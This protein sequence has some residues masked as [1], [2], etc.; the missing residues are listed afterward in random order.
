MPGL[1]PGRLDHVTGPAA[2]TG[3]GPALA[4]VRRAVARV[5]PTDATVLVL[6]ETGTGKELVARAVH[7]AEPAGTTRPFVPVSCVALA[8]GL[9]TSELFGHEAGAFTGAGRRRVGRFEQADGGTL[10]LDEAGEMPPDAQAVLLRALQERVIERVGGEA[11]PVDVRVVAATNRDLPAEVAAGRFRA[12]LY[13]RLAVFPVTVPPL[14]DRR[15]DISELVEQFTRVGRHAGTAGRRSLCSTSTLR[16]LAAHDWPGNVRELQNLVERA[17]ILSDGPDLAFDP[18]WLAGGTAAETAK[19]WAAQEKRRLL[20]ALRASRRPGVRPRRGG[21]PAGPQPDHPVRQDA[22]ARHRPHGRRVGVITGRQPTKLASS[23][24]GRNRRG[25]LLYFQRG[26]PGALGP[27]SLTPERRW[28]VAHVVTEPCV[29]CKHSDCVVVCPCE[30]FYA[31]D[32]QLYIDPVDCID[33]G[34]CVPECPVEAIFQ[35]DDVPAKWAGAVRLNADRVASAEGGRVA[36]GDGEAAGVT[37][38]PCGRSRPARRRPP[39]RSAPPTRRQHVASPPSRL[40]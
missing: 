7:A 28:P 3:T 33:C 8:P 26:T 16:A 22:E 4:A 17:V 14:R 24:A 27:P 32:R 12:D 29:G 31:D 1:R 2:L 23:P 39:P 13:Y 5:A 19:T 25:F 11:V 40:Y 30:C 21:P 38:R 10:F 18:G 37:T 9:I 6:G 36:A 20:D 15:E 35:E 34:A